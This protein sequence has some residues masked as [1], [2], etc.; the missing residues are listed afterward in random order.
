MSPTQR[1]P[2]GTQ[3]GGP[4]WDSLIE[5]QIRE[6]MA[7]GRFDELPHQGTSLPM[8]DDAAAGDR[9]MAFRMLRDAGYA[10][11]WIEA[12]KDARAGVDRLEALIGRGPRTGPA[13]R[14][15]LRRAVRDAVDDTN[16]AI[17]RVNAEAPTPRQHRRPLDLAAELDRL[18]GAFPDQA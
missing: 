6:A 8:E 15:R 13:S 4:T 1:D 17:E 16:R 11:P 5:R 10:P 7:D 3:H 9:A 14:D 2:D 18:E 12:D